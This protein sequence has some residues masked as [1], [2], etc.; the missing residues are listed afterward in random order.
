MHNNFK[1]LFV[2]W[3]LLRDKDNVPGPFAAQMRPIALGVTPLGPVT[4]G[5]GGLQGGTGPG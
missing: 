4:W 1:S 5:G 2:L 3:P